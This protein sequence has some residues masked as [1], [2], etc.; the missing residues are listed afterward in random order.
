M[1]E[2]LVT[3]YPSQLMAVA[4]RTSVQRSTEHGR[5]QFFN[6]LHDPAPGRRTVV[7]AGQKQLVGFHGSVKGRA[8]AMSSH[9]LKSAGPN[10]FFM[11]HDLLSLNVGI[12]VQSGSNATRLGPY[13][14][15]TTWRILFRGGFDIDFLLVSLL[16]KFDGI[17]PGFALLPKSRFGVQG[18]ACISESP[19]RAANNRFVSLAELYSMIRG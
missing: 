9:D 15:Y 3:A 17:Q 8:L 14:K 6:S 7:F 18:T 2:G 16:D 11:D 13:A 10:L 1:R 12:D 5:L 4:L 19:P